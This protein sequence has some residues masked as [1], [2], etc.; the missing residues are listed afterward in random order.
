MDAKIAVHRRLGVQMGLT[1]ALV[2]GLAFGATG[3][4]LL[5]EQR[6]VLTRE[7][8][9]RTL[10]ETRS[11]ALAASSPLLRHDPELGLHPFILKALE[12]T[13]DLVDVQVVDAEGVVQG[14]RDL[15]QVGRRFTP[16]AES[17]A[18]VLPL[19][20]GERAWLADDD[21]VIAQPIVHLGKPI[22]S[23]VARA[24]RA[25]IEATVRAA[26]TKMSVV[27]AAGTLAAIAAVVL[28]V[29]VSLRPLVEMRRG[30]ALLGRAT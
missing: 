28:L 22:G 11:L 27:A 1:V 26:Q 8:T 10:A 25:G 7:L 9:L 6:A 18:L 30:M 3:W 17:R 14:H 13:P 19:R 4:V 20:A 2:V 24:S 29:T 5:G 23:L 16:A 12:E 15:L 21:V